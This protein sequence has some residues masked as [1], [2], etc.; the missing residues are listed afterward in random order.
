MWSIRRS[1]YNQVYVGEFSTKTKH[2]Y[3]SY[4]TSLEIIEWEKTI[5]RYCPVKNLDFYIVRCIGPYTDSRD[6]VGRP[7]DEKIRG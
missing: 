4:M 2:K 5:S 7:T 6:T 3:R 1:I